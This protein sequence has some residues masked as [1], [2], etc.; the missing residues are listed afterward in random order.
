MTD[1]G[2]QVLRVIVVAMLVIGS[3]PP[4]SSSGAFALETAGEPAPA[5]PAALASA[6]PTPETTSSG[7]SRCEAN[8]A[9]LVGNDSAALGDPDVQALAKR[10]PMLAACGA[11]VRDSDEPCGL[12]T[13]D[14]EKSCRKTRMTFHELRDPAKRGF[15]FSDEEYRDC[16]ASIGA[17][18][19]DAIRTA[20]G[21]GDPSQCPAKQPFGA[22]CR[23]T[24]TLDPSL[25]PKE[26]AKECKRDVEH[27]KTF[28]DGLAGLRKSGTP[29]ERAL[30]AAALGEADACTPI[31][32]S[33][34]ED[35]AAATRP[36]AGRTAAPA[37]AG[38]VGGPRPARTPQL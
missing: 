2:V 15:I 38:K 23:A 1:H 16:V 20:I 32:Q 24:I 22:V 12:L 11:V 31:A 30:A 4:S 36:K 19:C 26:G 28:A 13:D 5:D 3:S 29:E 14:D 18:V 33:A 37:S 27:W 21:A 35:C 34:L 25:C 8:I 6:S 10:R 7:A 9:G 17:S